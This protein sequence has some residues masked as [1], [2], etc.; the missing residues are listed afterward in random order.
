M[1]GGGFPATIVTGLILVGLKYF[2]LLQEKRSLLDQLEETK[3]GQDETLQEVVSELKSQ[4]LQDT[5][6]INKVSQH[7]FFFL[8]KMVL[9]V[10]KKINLLVTLY[11]YHQPFLLALTLTKYLFYYRKR[12]KTKS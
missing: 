3:R 6:R 2:G 1:V 4:Q 9:M 11:T 12:K 10:L 5:A 7:V 8:V